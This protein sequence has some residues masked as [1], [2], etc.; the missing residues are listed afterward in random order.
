MSTAPEQLEHL[1]SEDSSARLETV[2]ELGALPS[3]PVGRVRGMLE[4]RDLKR[5]VRYTS[6]SVIALV[7]SEVCLLVLN[8]EMTL[9]V[10][11]AAIFA[12]LAGTVPS[13]LL[14]RYWIWSEADRSRA[15]RQ[16]VLYWLT[17]IISMAISSVATGAIA[18]E[19]HAHHVL[20][21]VILGALYLAVSIALWIA[22]YVAYQSFIF[23]SAPASAADSGLA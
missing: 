5:L 22:K 12:N 3:G 2:S 4:G 10:T 20:K 6:T 18:H 14:S 1:G 23:R 17:S 13:Y 11:V 21:L 7:R 8:A 16:V 9:T 19:D 15:A